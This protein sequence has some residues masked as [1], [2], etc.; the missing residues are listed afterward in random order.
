MGLGGRQPSV[1]C[2]SVL[3]HDARSDGTS[4]L[5]K[6]DRKRSVRGPREKRGRAQLLVNH[7]WPPSK[8]TRC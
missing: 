4:T 8:L 3:G 5:L 1:P 2:S 6:S 7:V